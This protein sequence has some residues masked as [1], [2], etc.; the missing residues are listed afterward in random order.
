[1]TEETSCSQLDF[2]SHV[3]IS[4]WVPFETPEAF[5]LD[6]AKLSSK[7]SVVLKPNGSKYSAVSAAAAF[8]PMFGYSTDSQWCHKRRLDLSYNKGISGRL[9]SSI[10]NLTNLSNL[11]LIGCSFYGSIPDTIGNLQKLTVLSLTN[12]S[13]SGSIPASIGHLSKLYWL[14]LA[15]NQL[16]G[17]IPVSN[18]NTPGL[19]MLLLAK[20]F[21]LDHNKLSGEIP[22]Q[23]FSSKMV[24]IHVLLNSNNLIG[25]I[26][27]TLGLVQTLEVIRFDRN[28]LSGSIP[29]NLS[30]L[31]N[32][33]QL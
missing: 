20:H 10:G 7:N 19:D 4:R 2:R 18:G 24:L 25:N 22:P 13:F 23:L 12:N 1:M 32:V 17:P 11:N 21:H 16:D 29:S 6:P 31:V 28:S 27:D 3:I 26:P 33:N 8:H 15:E 30:N 9:P 5:F 14:D